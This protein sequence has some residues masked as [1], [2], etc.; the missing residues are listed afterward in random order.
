[1][2]PRADRY[3]RVVAAEPPGT[4]HDS[5]YPGD[6]GCRCA[7]RICARYVTT[8]GRECPSAQA[9][10][11][12]PT[13]RRRTWPG[14]RQTAAPRSTIARRSPRSW[15]R[16]RRPSPAARSTTIRAPACSTIRTSCS[17][18]RRSPPCSPP[19]GPEAYPIALTMIAETIEAALAPQ[20]EDRAAQ[21]HGLMWVV[22]KAF[23]RRPRP[24]AVG[25]AGVGRG[26]C[27]APALDRHRHAAAAQDHRRDR[28]TRSPVRCSR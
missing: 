19:P 14:S 1:M 11:R 23:D 12:P 16:R 20:A 28:R 3:G 13:G 17:P 7:A 25:A 4:R 22:L 10:G 27:R 8:A 6:S 15:T 2:R 5:A 21:R 9:P 24:D 18:S 26:A